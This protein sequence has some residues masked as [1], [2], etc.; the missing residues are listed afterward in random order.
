[1]EIK[2]VCIIGGSGFVG[3]HIAHLLATREIKVRILTRRREYA[4]SLL[5]LPTVDVIETNIHDPRELGQLLVGVDAVINLVG[6]FW[7][8]EKRTA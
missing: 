1:M 5:V 6:I 3:Q 7:T 8:S 4:K 2:N